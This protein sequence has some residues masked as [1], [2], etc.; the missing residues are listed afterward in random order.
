[1]VDAEKVGQS[2]SLWRGYGW[3]QNVLANLAALRRRPDIRHFTEMDG[4]PGVSDSYALVAGAGPSLTEDLQRW[5]GPIIAV[6]GAALA[7]E[8]AGRQCALAVI[9][10]SLPMQDQLPRHG[11]VAASLTCDPDVFDDADVWYLSNLPLWSMFGALSGKR[12]LAYGG[13]A[14]G[15]ATALALQ[16]FDHVYLIGADLAWSPD[17]RTY[18]ENTP[19]ESQV[20]DKTSGVLSRHSS[21]NAMRVTNGVPP[22]PDRPITYTVPGVCGR[23]LTT[24]IEYK[25]QI[26][27]LQRRFE[28]GGRVS[29]ISS[30][31]AAYLRKGSLP[32]GERIVDFGRK[33]PETRADLDSVWY[34]LLRTATHARE[35][36][37]V[38]RT[39]PTL[40]PGLI[41][42]GAP[43]WSLACLAA[44]SKA[45]LWEAE[46]EHK[47][48]RLYASLS[49]IADEIERAF[50]EQE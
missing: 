28:S 21:R 16:W 30:S 23:E 24:P 25:I 36:S 42:G 45:R 35:V 5:A 48:L 27:W 41:V 13:F 22:V 46:P 15:A 49:A 6:N 9:A 19:W 34:A 38:M 44:V 14:L 43:F 1:M 3:F 18:A 50:D 17:G 47:L 33:R 10:D 29:N 26:E 20:F 31:G 32:Q 37:K 12:P 4:L 7:A 8:A 39:N 40:A 11:Y 2:T